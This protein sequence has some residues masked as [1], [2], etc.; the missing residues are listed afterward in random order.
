VAYAI[1]T[2][3]YN[4]DI[5]FLATDPLQT[6][7][8]PSATINTAIMEANSSGKSIARSNRI[9]IMTNTSSQIRYRF[10]GIAAATTNASFAIRPFGWIEVDHVRSA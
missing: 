2:T 1:L 8:T 6:D 3:N 5:F 9:E 10:T 7:S 4:A